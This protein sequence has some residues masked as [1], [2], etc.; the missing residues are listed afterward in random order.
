MSLAP[1]HLVVCA[2]TLEEGAAAVAAALGVALEPGGQH[3]VMGTHNR[4]LSLGPGEYLEVI[5]IDPDAAPPGRPRWFDLDRFAGAPRLTTWVARCD[6]LAAEVARSPEG[7]GAVHDLARGDYRWRMAIPGDGRLPFGGAFP[8]LI[9]WQGA[10]HPADRLPDRGCRLRRL[11][12]FHPRADD[13]R[14]ALAGRLHDSRIAVEKAPAEC[15]CA[16]IDTPAGP[17]VLE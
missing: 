2:A 10:L 17:R 14:R 15:L 9:A 13:L 11:T 3:P 16:E 7:T 4:L 12:L 8:G 1:D 6:D 5:A